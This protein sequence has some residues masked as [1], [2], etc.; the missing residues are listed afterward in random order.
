MRKEV[1][2]EA[3]VSEGVGTMWWQPSQFTA[4]VTAACVHRGEGGGV[5]CK[6]VFVSSGSEAWAGAC[7]LAWWTWAFLVPF[8]AP[9]IGRE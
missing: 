7:F 2:E 6:W 5:T 1:R 4:M 8:L 9:E 3:V